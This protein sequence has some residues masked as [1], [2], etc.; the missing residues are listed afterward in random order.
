MELKLLL[1]KLEPIRLLILDVDGV[2][3]DGSLYLDEE[4]REWKRFHAHDGLGMV[5]L[6]LV[7]IEVI[8][9]SGRAHGGVEIR[10]R[11]LGVKAYQGVKDKAGFVKRLAEDMR[12]SLNEI[13]YMG[14][15]W[16]DWGAMQLVGVRFAPSNAVQRVQDCADYVTQSSG[17]NGAVR[18]VC[19][20]I[21][22]LRGLSE[23]A[24]GLYNDGQ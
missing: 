9:L 10:A 8:W 15:D 7:G 11:G 2:L 1:D 21:L 14:D 12:L 13:A 6:Q 20:F 4:G 24:Y 16:N 18:E 23:R 22:E 5:L 19:D 3:T 17:G